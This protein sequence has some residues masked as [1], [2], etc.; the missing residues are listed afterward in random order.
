MGLASRHTETISRI[1][2]L[3]QELITTRWELRELLSYLEN[4]S[5]T[6]Y[7]GPCSSQNTKLSLD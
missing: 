5:R 2:F 4:L 1:L 3:Y 6:N 7:S